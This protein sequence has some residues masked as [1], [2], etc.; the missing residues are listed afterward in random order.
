MANVNYVA[1]VPQT[2]EERVAMYMKCK[3]ADLAMMMAEN[4]KHLCPEACAELQ[5]KNKNTDTATWTSVSSI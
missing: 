2:F 4:Q 5:D 3:K 1:I